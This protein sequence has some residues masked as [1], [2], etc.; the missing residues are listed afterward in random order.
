MR[1]SVNFLFL[2]CHVKATILVNILV[3]RATFKML[4]CT[5]STTIK[6]IEENQS[7][8]NEYVHKIC[9]FISSYTYRKNCRK[10]KTKQNNN[11]KPV[12]C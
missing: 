1:G 12:P 5:P 6:K 2:S 11:K 7:Y 8:F 4:Q 10:S 9:L 3:K